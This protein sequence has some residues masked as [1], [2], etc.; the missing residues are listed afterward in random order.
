MKITIVGDKIDLADELEEEFHAEAMEAVGEAADIVLAD[1]KQ[2]LSRRR[3]P[4][5]SPPGEPPALQEGDLLRSY[6]RVT[7][8]VR[9]RVATSGI[10]SRHP[11]AN[12]VEFGAVDRRGIRTLARPHVRPA[13][14]A[15][16]PA[17]TE[18][19]QRRLT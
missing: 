8:K 3:G 13:F 19:L 12:R 15:M 9:G 1:V 2:R 7:P 11:G 4:E 18:L 5:A 17:V 10:Y 14:A 6:R 16:E